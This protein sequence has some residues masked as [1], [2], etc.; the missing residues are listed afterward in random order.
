MKGLG[1]KFNSQA[2][3]LGVKHKSL[4]YTLGSK[5]IIPHLVSNIISP[6]KPIVT[7]LS[8]NQLIPNSS[9]AS[10][11]QYLPTGMKQSYLEKRK[12]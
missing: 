2:R 1:Q 5:Q 10:N 3:G 12:R 9:N 7:G 6:N 4:A 11:I 8:V